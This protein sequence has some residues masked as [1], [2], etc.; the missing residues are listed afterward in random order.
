MICVVR[1]GLLIADSH[2]EVRKEVERWD[3]GVEETRGSQ[4]GLF[5]MN[6]D[7]GTGG[8]PR[9][10]DVVK[11]REKIVIASARRH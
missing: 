6:L 5:A 1:R 10:E 3:V 7:A 2:N 11:G 4:G 9:Q 8:Q